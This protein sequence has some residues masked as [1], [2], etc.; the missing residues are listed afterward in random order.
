[1]TL[2]SQARAMEKPPP[3]AIP[4]TAATTGLGILR[5]STIA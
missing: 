5:I 1:M 4:L 3:A 2:K